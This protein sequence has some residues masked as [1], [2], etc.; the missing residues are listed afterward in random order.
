M[1]LV[2]IIAIW[3]YKTTPYE[4]TFW[5]HDRFQVLTWNYQI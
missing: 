1:K 4:R 2:S 5:Q 3:E